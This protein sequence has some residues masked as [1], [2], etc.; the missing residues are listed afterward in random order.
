MA[1]RPDHEKSRLQRVDLPASRPV[2]RGLGHF[3]CR[4]RRHPDESAPFLLLPAHRDALDLV[5]RHRPGRCRSWRVSNLLRQASTV[6]AATLL[7]IWQSSFAGE[8]AAVLSLGLPLRHVRCRIAFV[9]V[10]VETMTPWLN[11]SL[12]PTQ[13]DASS[14]ASRVPS[15]G[16]ALLSLH[17]WRRKSSRSAGCRRIGRSAAVSKTSQH[18]A[19]IHAAKSPERL[20]NLDPLRLIVSL[21]SGHTFLSTTSRRPLRRK[22]SNGPCN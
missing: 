14:S 17:R 10:I 2:D 22:F 3:R 20:C 12:R 1:T 5:L 18:I 11:K 15:F 7:H 8:Q 6:S 16:T 21:I 13:V 19:N 4:R 9:F